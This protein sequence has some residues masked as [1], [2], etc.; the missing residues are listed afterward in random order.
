[1]KAWIEDHVALR[2]RPVVG[3]KVPHD[4][5]WKCPSCGLEVHGAHH[6]E[7]ESSGAPR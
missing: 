2:P 7:E 5:L 3:P 1:M 4:H 6:E